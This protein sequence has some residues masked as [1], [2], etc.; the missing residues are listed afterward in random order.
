MKFRKITAGI[1]A[2]ALMGVFCPITGTAEVSKSGD[3]LYKK[4]IFM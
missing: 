1:C 3:L 4:E 2:M